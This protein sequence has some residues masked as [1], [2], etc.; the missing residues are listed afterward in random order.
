MLLV[1]KG[2]A[3]REGSVGQGRRSV[4]QVQGEQASAKKGSEVK[5]C[6]RSS[7]AQK[8]ERRHTG[9]AGLGRVS[10]VN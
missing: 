7:A 10:K 9:L 5:G 1:H 4:R 8:A 3:A 6:L 2:R